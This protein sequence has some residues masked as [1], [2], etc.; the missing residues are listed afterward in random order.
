MNVRDI[1]QAFLF[2]VLLWLIPFLLAFIIFPLRQDDR[3]FFESIM[4]VAI[5]VTTAILG[6]RYF[7]KTEKVVPEEG[8]ALGLIWMII[9]LFLDYPMFTYGPMKMEYALYWKDIGFTYLI[10][11]TVTIG[12]SFVASK[13][14]K[15]Q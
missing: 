13:R 11:P 9:S 4:P 6:V 7:M 2:G 5:A 3:V 12:L 10:I 15:K 1:K 14:S 8:L